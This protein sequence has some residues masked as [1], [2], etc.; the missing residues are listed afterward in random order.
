LST[1]PA[2]ASSHSPTTSGSFPANEGWSTNATLDQIG[3]ALRAA[4][5]VVVTTHAKPDGDAAGSTLA[6]ARSLGHAGIP[7]HI[8]AVG[9]LPRWMA[10]LCPPTGVR[11]FAPGRPMQPTDGRPAAPIDPDL[12]MIVDTG[13]WA[14]LAELRPWLEKRAD[15]TIILD[16]HLH[17]D[18]A[19]ATRR[20]VD[21]TCAS[22]TQ[23]LAMLCVD[24]CG[25][26]SAAK[27]PLNVAEP[28][29]LGLA[30]DTGWFRYSSV[31]PAT[32]R[33]AADLIEA[34]VDHTRLYGFIEQQDVASRWQLLGRALSTLELHSV[35]APDDAATMS[36][37]LA[38]FDSTGADR[39]DTSG[40][41]DM[42]LTVASVQVA[43]VLTENPVNPG[44]PPLT[45]YSLRSKP[46]PSAVDV[47]KVCQRLGGGGHARAAGAKTRLD[48]TAAKH[49]L[50]EALK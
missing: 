20:Y 10:E 26:A 36:L 37:T 32:L 22:A 45:K 3:K 6:L 46:G 49:A 29:Y 27:L 9:P 34:G 19:V 11:E 14:Q 38:D 39:N 28:L 43:A 23:A 25:V 18:A 35:R 24:L 42:L 33:L 5:S 31:T 16:H 1:R 13:S 4:G 12:C 48:L 17:G 15:R 47:N 2:A 41:A 40:F 7:S 8:W 44:E 30:T 50:L 21:P